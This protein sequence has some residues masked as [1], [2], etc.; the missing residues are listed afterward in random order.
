MN[1]RTVA[2]GGAIGLLTIA[3]FEI[4][5]LLPA[6]VAAGT[7]YVAVVLLGAWLPWRSSL[8]V[9]AIIAT[10][11]TGLGYLLDLAGEPTGTWIPAANRGLTAFAIWIAAALTFWRRARE[12][13]TERSER[14]LQEAQALAHLGS[15]E[16]PRDPAAPIRWSAEVARILGLDPD[17]PP[18]STESY[19]ER[20]VH[21]DDRNRVRETLIGAVEAGVRHEIE[22]R[23]R[24]PDGAVRH[25]QSLGKPVRDGRGGVT[26]VVGTLLDVTDRREADRALRESEERFRT[27][28]QAVPSATVLLSAD[29]T[30]LELNRAAE[31]LY[32]TAR[33]EA[34]GRNYCDEF[35]AAPRRPACCQTLADVV[36]GREVRSVEFPIRRRDGETRDLLLNAGPLRDGGRIAGVLLAGED[37][38]DRRRAEAALREREAQLSAI[39]AT[40]P[41]AIV[42]V[43]ERGLIAAFSGAAERLFGYGAD[44]VIGRSVSMLMPEKFRARHE[45]I[46]AGYRQQA[47]LG[48]GTAREVEALRKDGSTFRA[49]CA[50]GE[51]R[52]PDGQRRFVS[53]LRDLSDRIALE[54]QL[55]HAQKMEA[56]GQLTGGVAHDFN[57]LLTAIIGNL[58]MLDARLDNEDQRILVGEALEAAGLGA[59]L[60]DRLLSFGR[61]Q[62]LAPRP[63]D[64]AAMVA[65]L[66]GLLRRTLGETIEISTIIEPDLAPALIDPGQIENALLNLAINARDAMP[67]GGRLT[68]EV[69]SARLSKDLAARIGDVAPGRYAVIAVSDT[70]TGMP[71]EVRDRAFDPFFTTKAGGHGTGLGLSMVY[72]FCKQSKGHVEITSV[73]GSGTTVR[74]Y[75]PQDHQNTNQPRADDWIDVEPCPTAECILLVEDDR[76]LRRVAKARLEE[77]GYRVVEAENGPAALRILERDGETIDLLFT[78]I[79]MPGGMP[80]HELARIARE[81]WPTLAVLLTSGYPGDSLNLGTV[82]E[83]GFGWLRKPYNRQ[84]LARAVRDALG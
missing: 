30:I 58:E 65:G 82:V 22:Y 36:A 70:G 32:G 39:I 24:R 64:L 45:A 20:I 79:V 35:V 43:D 8:L 78:D 17:A 14:S 44:E 31:K 34:L 68:I 11:L 77:L 7:L 26:K 9:L 13:E 19:I 48:A 59:Q 46:I 80:G 18:M 1:I 42:T 69:G 50:V 16:R 81:R 61:R 51:I 52:L 60:T 5:L 29:G 40:A 72:G 6:G 56:L 63:V 41:E 4:D 33:A 2:F 37:V 12:R 49:E 53:F 67:G 74:L 10:A 55:R 28:F 15:Y 83:E 76:R 66:T 47:G 73:P 25:V 3:A 84:Q 71:P 57:N 23:I 27:V 54:Q 75:L 38:T 21:P 62:P